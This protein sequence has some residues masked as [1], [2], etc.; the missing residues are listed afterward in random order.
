MDKRKALVANIWCIFV[1]E[2][3]MQLGRM[4]GW[5]DRQS[6]LIFMFVFHV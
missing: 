2:D 4:D 1:S 6:L 5:T 3:V